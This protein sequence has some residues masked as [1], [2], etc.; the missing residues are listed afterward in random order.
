[1]AVADEKTLRDLEFEQVKDALKSFCS[2][3]LGEQAVAALT[4]V[5]ERERIEAG[6]AEVDEAIT[7]LDKAGRFS[8]AGIEDLAPVLE[9]A[10][11]HV[12]LDGEAFLL[13]LQTIDATERVR[14][15]LL[16]RDDLPL[17]RRL[18]ERPSDATPLARRIRRTIDEAGELCDDASPALRELVQRRAT[19]ERRVERKL[20]SLIDANP[21]L[22]SEPVITRRMGRLVVPIRSGAV[23]AMGFVVHDRSATGQTLYAEPS[24]LVPENNAL[25]TLEAEIQEERRR[26]LRELTAALVEKES[27]FLRDRAV[28]S[29]LDSLF[30]RAGF[31]VAR[32]CAFPQVSP[33][34]ALRD[35]RH[36]LLDPARVVPISL[37]LDGRTPMAVI[38]GPNTGGKTVTL[39]T[40]GLLALMNQA[41]IPI[42]ASADSELPIL[43]LVRSDI[44]D[45]QS[46]SQ[47]LSTFSAHMKHIVAALARADAGTLI[48]LD[49]LGAGTDP[50]E[51]AAIGL[52]IAERLLETGAFVAISTHLTPLKYFAIRHPAVK[53]ASME[54]DVQTLSP[55]FRVV[56]GLPGKSNAFVIAHRLGLPEA[57]VDRARGFLSQG[58]I[59]AED[60]IEELQR[61][62]QRLVSEHGKAQEERAAAVR[63]RETYEEKLA[64]FERAKEESL[65]PRIRA[66]D[67]FLRRSQQEAEELLASL[68]RTADPE[69]VR[70]AHRTLSSL[71]QALNAEVQQLGQAEGTVLSGEELRIGRRVHVRSLDADGRIVQRGPNDKVTVDL[72]GIR[73]S[74]EEGD[75]APP[76]RAREAA[77]K[78]STLPPPG[79]R[80]ERVPLQINVRGMTVPE[81]LRA[82]ESYIDR[83]LLADVRQASILHGKGT[84]ALR[85]AVCDYLSSCAF[86]QTCGAAPPQEGGDGV[87]VFQLAGE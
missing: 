2:C 18:A 11:E 66:L 54:F 86:V 23:G 52:A 48:L 43:S 51:G 35:A 32:G 20:R 24:G 15:S 79:P 58:E 39:K 60:I 30:A 41:A 13:I 9:R 53:T 1:M 57:L 19:L 46:I 80:I 34:I 5:D 47:N 10:K 40:L 70:A 73:V 78:P 28:L 61:E 22:I 84:G 6:R 63:L 42:P 62:R 74:T 50:Q 31:A 26:I 69:S 4:P 64:G 38:T 55:T 56:E 17:L 67:A 16:A 59:R 21:E 45:E 25:A 65:S 87:T 3:R 49:E 82:V 8:L 76:G 36:P 75:L 44:G 12:S 14:A 71:R 81:A 27:A 33:R 85:D 72:D 68:H 37:S 7:L 77:R 83:L 29:H